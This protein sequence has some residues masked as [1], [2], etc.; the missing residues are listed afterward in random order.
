MCSIV[1]HDKKQPSYEDEEISI[2]DR[3]IPKNAT[4]EA[5][6]S[7]GATLNFIGIFI[8]LFDGNYEVICGKYNKAMEKMLQKIPT[9]KSKPHI[10]GKKLQ[11]LLTEIGV[12]WYMEK[13]LRDYHYLG[14]QN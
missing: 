3:P 4:I 14:Y 12:G 9:I 7:L 10:Q 5:L 2:W 8:K 1:S 6:E 11:K 13:I